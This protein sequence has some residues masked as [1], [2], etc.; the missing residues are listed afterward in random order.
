VNRLLPLLLLLLPL[1]GCPST[2]P[3]QPDDDD[4]TGPDCPDSCTIGD[5]RC[6]GFTIEACG[7]DS[8]GCTAWI[9]GIDCA[10]QGGTCDDT[11]DP[12]TCTDA[13]GET[14]DDGEQNQD[15]TDVDCGGVCAPCDLGDG[16]EGGDDCVSGYCDPTSLTCAQ[17]PGETCTDGAQNGT[18]TD[19]DCGGDL[20]A[21]CGNG[22]GCDGA[23]DCLSGYCDPLSDTCAPA[24]SE[25]CADGVLNGDETDVDCGGPLC[26]ACALG[27]DCATATDCVSGYCDPIS[28][29]CASNPGETCGDGVHNQDET[30]V[31]CGGASCAPCGLADACA[32]NSDCSSGNCDVGVTD[33]CVPASA[34]TC[35]DGVTNGDE[36]DADCGGPTCAACSLGDD[37]AA[38]GDCASG[39]CDVGVTDTCVPGS[40]A[41]CFD[42]VANGDE[43]DTDCGGPACAPCSLGDVC[44]GDGDCSSGACDVGNSDTC[45]QATGA[46]CG[47]GLLNQ[48]ETDT[49][50]GGS[51]CA[52]CGVGDVCS[53]DDDCGTG[54]CDGFV[55]AVASGETC[56]DGVLNQDE[57]D[58][59][60]GGSACAPCQVGDDCAGPD[61]CT[62]GNCDV[63]DTDV[64]VT[65]PTPTCGDGL[66]N[67]DE[68]DVDCGGSA[69]PA[70]DLGDF[71]DEQTD[72]STNNCDVAVTNQCVNPAVETCGDGL[73]NQDE[74]ATD[75]GGGICPSCIAPSFE[76]NED[77]ESGDLST[78][79]WVLDG[80]GTHDWELENDPSACHGGDWCLRTSPLHDL[81]E[82]SEFSLSLSI[83]EDDDVTFWAWVDAE[84]NEHWFRFYI[85]GVLQTEVTDQTGW[86]FYSFPV[87]AT[88]PNGPNREVTFEYSRSTFVDPN[89]PPYNT[90]RIDDIDIPSWNTQPTVPD[91]LQPWDNRLTTSAQPTMAWTSTDPDF[92]PITYELQYDTDPTFPLP[93]SSGEITDE[94][95]IPLSAL[96]VDVYY[97]RV[98]S[99]DDSDFRW[100]DWSEVWS[101]TADSGYEYT[102][103]W[104]QHV[105]EQ[106]ETNDLGA[107]VLSGD[108]VVTPSGSYTSPWS[109]WQDHGVGGVRHHQFNGVPIGASATGW[110]EVNTV[111]DWGGTNEGYDLTLDSLYVGYRRPTTSGSQT[112]R[113]NGVSFTAGVADG[114]V[115]AI[116]DAQSS[117][118]GGDS[119]ARVSY[120]YDTPATVVSTDI[121]F[122]IFPTATHWEKVQWIG[123]DVPITVL[124]GTGTPL[125]DSVLPGNAAGFTDH[126]VHLWDVDALTYPVLRLQADLA[127]GGSLQEWRVVGNTVYE[128][129][130]NYTTDDAQGWVGGD[131]GSPVTVTT[132]GDSLLLEGLAAGSDPN[133]QY[134]FGQPVD[135]TRF[136]T[137]E[138]T[139][140]SSNNNFLDDVT[141]EWQSNFGLFDF[142]RSFTIEDVFIQ[143]YQDLTFDLTVI[144]QSP[145]QPWQ[146]L[147][148]GLRIDG[149]T[150]FLDT[151]GDPADGWFE[152][153]R[154][155]I[156]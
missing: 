56:G 134:L 64:C 91:L 70:C 124:D 115:T 68:T 51:I 46:T 104:R 99:K 7:V 95:F 151:L 100:S 41:T 102:D 3:G 2:T 18:E 114:E 24:P 74:E 63:N 110:I 14:C 78:F 109:G 92:D 59:D 118:N 39:A 23:T 140:R 96:A 33:T 149:V 25:T 79:P 6:N 72:C 141:L 77:W 117:V 135:A 55:C 29:T 121:D 84:P 17:D 113:H 1:L 85:D 36:T 86:Q 147:I 40:V 97:W 105:A 76:T 126:T 16:C 108:T 35:S 143:S 88:G 60:C 81:A 20:C 116:V 19:I 153:D 45:I 15:E 49:D 57:T 4:A 89:H 94:T 30:D 47:D 34:A 62:T 52:A 127:S 131:F 58:V 80:D 154:I 130:F 27:D 111:G 32:A 148:E 156:Y 145:Q 22:G 28:D 48:D 139:L 132:D 125:P 129:L 87:L 53:I 54:L 107:A 42:G 122:S 38:N 66:L 82:T 31:D 43:T 65:T 112:Y 103:V 120:S 67:S 138:V 137:L 61:D 5:S 93:I 128:W 73:L 106:F 119:R 146:G 44:A 101:F 136:T 133:I 98:R 26:S 9:S 37:C 13:A 21:P 8:E 12:P 144:P 11:T 83:R 150:E 69:C 50:C 155:T 142:V 90:I 10:A 75:C 123:S 71:C 152:I